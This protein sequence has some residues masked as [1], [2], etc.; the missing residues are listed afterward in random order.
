[1]TPL[2]RAKNALIGKPL[3]NFV[4]I[5]MRPAFRAT[6][7]QACN[8]G[9]AEEWPILLLPQGTPTVD[10]VITVAAAPAHAPTH[11]G[12]YPRLYWLVRPDTRRDVED[13]L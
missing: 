4:P 11:S 12:G 7:N 3:V 8:G 6:I 1:M 13:L 5:T 2:G 9:A 10:V